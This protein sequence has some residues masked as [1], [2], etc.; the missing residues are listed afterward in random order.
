[1]IMSTLFLHW[2]LSSTALFSLRLLLCDGINIP[3]DVVCSEEEKRAL[4]SFKR[5]L[6][7]PSNRLSSWSVDQENCCRWT[8]VRCNNVTGQVVELH[9]GNPYGDYSNDFESYMTHQLGGKI[10]PSLLELQSLSYLDLS[11]NNFTGASVPSFLGSVGSLRYLNLSYAFFERSIL[12]HL[13]NLSGLRVLDLSF[14]YQFHVDKLSW[15]S[16]LHDLE[17]LDMSGIDLHNATDWHPA[18]SVLPSFSELLL[19]SCGLEGLISHQ[20][21]N[22]SSLRHLDLSDNFDLY[23]DDLSW[24][25]RLRSLESLNMRSVDLHMAVDWLQAVSM[26]PSLSELY[27]SSCQLVKIIPP[28]SY[29]NF[30]SLKVL[31]LSGNNFRSKIPDLLFNLTTSLL[32][33]DLS[34]NFLYG[35]IPSIISNLR[36]LSNLELEYNHLITGRIPNEIGQLKHLECLSLSGNSLYGPIPTSVGNLSSLR[37]LELFE[38][39]LNGTLPKSVAF[40]SNLE[41]L[42][43]HHNS[44]AGIIS[45][46]NFAKLSK[47]KILYMSSNSLFFEVSSN[48]VPPFQL[49]ELLMRSCKIGPGFP[50]WLQT[51]TSFYALDISQS[52]I[53]GKAPEWFWKW[54]SGFEYINLSDNQING[55]ISNVLLNSSFIEMSSNRFGSQLPRLSPHVE[56]L[57]L[58]NSSIFGPICPVLCQEI[59]RE[60]KLRVLDLSNNLLSG[61]ISCC[62]MHFPY[63]VHVNLGRNNLSEFLQVPNFRVLMQLVTLAMPT[64]VEHHSTKIV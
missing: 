57:N 28:L 1:M 59:T 30:T 50:A 12:H 53:S 3:N 5:G 51:Q 35:H 25:A 41:E 64:S 7:D 36:L 49:H 33:L 20:L 17:Y 23:V 15:I 18:V 11:W 6:T 16:H 38:N 43:V 37:I 58:A 56:M 34:Y 42:N 19:S 52:G 31:H 54:V 45:E 61:G 29:D 26:L 40:L 22:L 2:L 62:W 13:G 63:L 48:W 39:Q 14:N 32:S 8:G 10:T 21:G 24:I 55:D 46:V 9:L 47:L 4:L 44:L 27:F 60:S